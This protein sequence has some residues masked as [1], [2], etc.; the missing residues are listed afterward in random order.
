MNSQFELYLNN[1][2]KTNKNHTSALHAILK[3]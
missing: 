1:S 3:L 2:F